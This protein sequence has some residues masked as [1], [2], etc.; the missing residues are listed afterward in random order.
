MQAKPEVVESA[1]TEGMSALIK[2]EMRLKTES[3]NVNYNGFNVDA[4]Q[5]T[6]FDFHMERGTVE[7][8]PTKASK[9]GVAAEAMASDIKAAFETRQLT[10]MEAGNLKGVLTKLTGDAKLA[11]AYVGR[12]ID[13]KADSGYNEKQGKG[14]DEGKNGKTKLAPLTK[15]IKQKY[16]NEGLTQDKIDEIV[17]L[18]KSQKLEP[19]TYLGKEYIEEHLQTLRILGQ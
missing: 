7:N 3:R 8:N 6:F 13:E 15:E 14:K 5:A 12:S 1:L 18:P 2:I 19:D 16:D 10:E 11:E 17:S 9:L 4:S